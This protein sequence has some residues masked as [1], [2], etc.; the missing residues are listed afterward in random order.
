MLAAFK[1]RP[2]HTVAAPALP[3]PPARDLAGMMNAVDR[4]MAVIEFNPDG[5]IIS[6]N[7][8]FSSAMGYALDE[9]EGRH[10]RMFVDAAARGNKIGA[11]ILDQLELRAKRLG[12]TELK[13]E[14]GPRQVEALGLYAGAGYEPCDLFGEYVHPPVTSRCFRKLL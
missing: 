10:H 8:N 1:P 6:A 3:A 4:V 7:A 14:T 12:I 5:T 11:A 9:I 13:L 2:V